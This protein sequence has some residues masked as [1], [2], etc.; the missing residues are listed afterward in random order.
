MGAGSSPQICSAV[1]HV[2]TK[3]LLAV[4]SL[5]FFSMGVGYRVTTLNR[6]RKIMYS[7]VN[8]TSKLCGNRI[9]TQNAY[10]R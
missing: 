2:V 7:S 10:A 1:M 9:G 4:G 3:Q 8:G 5:Y 6:E